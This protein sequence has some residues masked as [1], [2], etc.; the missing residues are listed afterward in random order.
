MKDGRTHLAHQAEHAVDLD[1]GAVLAVTLQGVDKGDTTTLVETLGE[2]GMAVAEQVGREARRSAAGE[3]GRHR[4]DGDRQGLSQRRGGEADEG[5]RGAQLHSGEET[6]G[7][8]ELGGQS[9]GATSG[10][11]EPAAGRVGRAQ[12]RALL[13]DGAVCDAAICGGTKTF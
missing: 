11:C 6:K 12:L 7:V 10:V 5:V 2:A 13:R 3:R 8:T 1:T 9:G 4:R